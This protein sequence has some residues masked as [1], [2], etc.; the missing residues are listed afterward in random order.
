MRRPEALLLVIALVIVL[1]WLFRWETLY[2]GRE[3]AYQMTRWTGELRWLTGADWQ[4]VEQSK[5]TG[6]FGTNDQPA[7]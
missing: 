1:G 7:K 6:P 4:P 3:S 5:P 2:A